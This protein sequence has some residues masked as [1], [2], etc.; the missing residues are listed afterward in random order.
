MK[1]EVSFLEKFLKLGLFKKY[2]SCNMLII[3]L[4]FCFFKQF[5]RL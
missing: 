1:V 2:L 5:L 4:L 3:M